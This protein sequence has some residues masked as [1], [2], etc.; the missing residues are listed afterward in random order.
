MSPCYA[1]KYD[2]LL[3]SICV[4]LYTVGRWW[5]WRQRITHGKT[6]T[7][8]TCT[9]LWLH[10]CCI[11]GASLL[12]YSTLFFIHLRTISSEDQHQFYLLILMRVCLWLILLHGFTGILNL[13]E[14]MGQYIP[15]FLYNNQVALYLMAIFPH[16]S[17]PYSRL[18]IFA[19]LIWWH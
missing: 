16:A 8:F 3:S 10:G 2:V 6:V 18:F 5:G 15:V 14:Y 13:I 7:S 17:R 1:G 12:F 4:V 9:C 19:T 11:S